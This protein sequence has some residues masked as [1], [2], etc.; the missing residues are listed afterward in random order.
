MIGAGGHAVSVSDIAIA[1]GYEQ[2]IYAI[3]SGFAPTSR[4]HDQAPSLITDIDSLSKES[5]CDYCVAIGDNWQRERLAVKGSSMMPYAKLVCLVHP[6]AYVSPS[7]QIMPGTV[8]MPKV[9]IGARCTVGKN[10]I[11][12][13]GAVIDHEC[14]VEDFSS[15]GPHAVMGGRS[16]LGFRSSICIGATVSHGINIGNDTILGGGAFLRAHLPHSCIAYGVPA[17]RVRSRQPYDPYL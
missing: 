12:N 7:A 3:E 9:A 6:S 1:L 14:F 2:I 5:T 4:I 10:V 17:Q 16:R 13:T 11:V 15:I 8:V